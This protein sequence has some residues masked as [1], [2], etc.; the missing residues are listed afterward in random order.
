MIEISVSFIACMHNV[1]ETLMHNVG[2]INEQVDTSLNRPFVV[3]AKLEKTIKSC[4][5]IIVGTKQSAEYVNGNY[6]S[7]VRLT[8]TRISITLRLQR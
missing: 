2:E 7:D 8:L 3:H 1:V 5:H 4:V 6:P